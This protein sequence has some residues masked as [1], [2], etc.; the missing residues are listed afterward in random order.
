[1]LKV[2]EK[3][4]IQAIS[5]ED[6]K[7]HLRLDHAEED[8]Y[9]IHLIETA[10]EYVERYLNRCLL[11]QKLS[12]TDQGKTNKDGFLEIKLPRPNIISIDRVTSMRSGSARYIVKRYQLVDADINPTLT[13]Y[14]KDAFVEI[15]YHS[16]YGVYPNHRPSPIKHALLLMVADL[17]ENRGGEGVS[18]SS[19]Y[20]TLLEP[21]RARGLA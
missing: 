13:L 7:V 10:T 9:L 15:V 1:M 11:K 17:Y 6:V 20:K 5:L 19:F 12:F 18:Q 21:Y 16:G 14:A 3:P 4:E 2:I 8:Q